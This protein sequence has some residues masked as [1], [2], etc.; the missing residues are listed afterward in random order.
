MHPRN[1]HSA[2]YDFPALV[3]SSPAL[4]PLLCPHPIDGKPS[5]D[6]GDPTS[7]TELNRALLRHHYGIAT[8]ELPRGYLTPP[9]PGRADYIHHLADLLA[10]ENGGA[11]PRDRTVAV[12]DIGVGANCIYPIV[13][14]AEYGWRFV[15]TDI[16]AGAIAGARAILNANPTLAAHVE[17]RLQ[18]SRSQIFRGVLRPGEQFAVTLCNPPFHASAAEAESGT[19]RKLRNLSGQTIARTATVLNFGGQAHE[20]WT[21]GGELAFVRRMIAESTEFAAQCGW[22][23]SLVS[24]SGHV[25]LLRAQLKAVKATRVRTIAMAQGQKQSRILAWSFR[26]S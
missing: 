5:I 7:V 18:R 9:V 1:R 16:N 12:L 25:P 21:A 23:T 26:S 20:L 14:V 10:E 6:F 22:F 2:G 8:W 15:G 3:R 24:K 13:G 11:I 4:A 19:R 17:L